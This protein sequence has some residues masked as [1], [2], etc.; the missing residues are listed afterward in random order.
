MDE[1]SRLAQQMHELKGSMLAME[2]FVNSLTE[3]LSSDARL[4][5]Q[6]FYASES[7]AYRAA[8]MASTAPEAT[9][10]AF[11]R[12]VDRA[13]RLLGEPRGSGDAG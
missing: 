6:A 4:V 5:V 11:E 13:L 12:D 8:L 3:A 1:T 9:V 2:C 10:G 7:S